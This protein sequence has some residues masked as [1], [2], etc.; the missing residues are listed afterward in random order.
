MIQDF[1]F[2][3]EGFGFLQDFKDRFD[4]TFRIDEPSDALVLDAENHS[5]KV[6]D[7]ENLDDFK[8]AVVE[9]LA[10]GKNLLMS[11]YQ[12]S[13]MEYNEDADY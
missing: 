11:R 13:E 1:V 7:D 8:A 12:D 6:K 10:T 5:Y 3:A 2:S 9:S 4:C